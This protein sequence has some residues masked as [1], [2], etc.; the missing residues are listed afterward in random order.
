MKFFYDSKRKRFKKGI[1]FIIAVTFL[2]SYSGIGYASDGL[3]LK[4]DAESK[5]RLGQL[6]T[7]LGVE[8]TQALPQYRDRLA[9]ST[10]ELHS[11]Q[12]QPTPPADT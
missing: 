3:A 12:L 2:F 11:D 6:A 10:Q 7:D 1:S 4:S 8:A 9:P 5:K